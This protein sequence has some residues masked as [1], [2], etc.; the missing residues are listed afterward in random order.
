M[1]EYRNT[2]LLQINFYIERLRDKL[3]NF[4][5]KVFFAFNSIVFISIILFYIV[6]YKGSYVSY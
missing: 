2:D 1:K 6:H 3:I 4:A 5:V